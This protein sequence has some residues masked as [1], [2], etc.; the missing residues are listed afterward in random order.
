[1]PLGKTR[2]TGTDGSTVSH[3]WSFSIPLGGT[4]GVEGAR[5]YGLGLMLAGLRYSRSFGN[6]EIKN[7]R[8]TK[9]GRDMLS[10]YFGYEFGFLDRN[11]R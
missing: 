6:V 8:N 11:K 5:K 7:S 2:Y 3:P 4:I 10:L 1:V 9:Y